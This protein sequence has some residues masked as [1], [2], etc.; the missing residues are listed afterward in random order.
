[1]NEIEPH[2]E[3]VIRKL[4]ASGY[5]PTMLSS[6]LDVPVA[7]VLE[8]VPPERRSVAAA[9]AELQ[10]AMRELAWRTIEEAMLILDE[11]TVPLKLKLIQKLAGDLGRVISVSDKDELADM[12]ES[13]AA[14]AAEIR[15]K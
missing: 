8:L 5:D 1:V 9:D 7:G 11:G 12:R 2:D 6:A 14:L 10:I 3:P 13:F 15:G 4:L